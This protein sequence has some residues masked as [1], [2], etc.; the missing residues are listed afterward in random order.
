MGDDARKVDLTGFHPLKQR[1]EIALHVCLSR[2]HGEPLVH[3]RPDRERHLT[4]IDAGDGQRPALAHRNDHFL[5]R[6]RLV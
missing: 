4:G 2:F 1:R 3:E 5:Q 6:K